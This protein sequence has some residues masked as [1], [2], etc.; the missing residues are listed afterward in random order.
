MA[1]CP[2]HVPQLIIVPPQASPGVAG[3]C[4]VLGRYRVLDRLEQSIAAIR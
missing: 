3:V 1:E 2:I 4:E